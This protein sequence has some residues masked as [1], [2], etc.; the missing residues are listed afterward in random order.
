MD[1]LYYQSGALYS[2]LGESKREYF[3]EDGTPKTIES[4]LFG[5]LHGE[6]LLYWPNGKLKRQ[7]NFLNGVRNGLDQMWSE[8][9]VLLDE[10]R[11]EAGKPVGVH[12]RL[13]R[14]SALIE[15]IEYLQEGRF[16]LRQWDDAGELRVEA[17]WLD[18]DTY[19]E[20]VWD[21]FQGVWVE[22]EGYWNG[23]QL[24]YV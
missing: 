17:I 22:K 5:R 19:R 9:G 14:M 23:S 1:Y 21:R 16:N 11:Y 3:Y 4:Y 24:V 12:R 10:G 2:V 13:N 18:L 20:K 8:D 7:C 15:E 6:S